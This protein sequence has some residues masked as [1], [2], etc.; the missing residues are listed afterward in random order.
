MS[1]KPVK[2]MSI[3]HARTTPKP[4]VANQ[5]DPCKWC[6]ITREDSNPLQDRRSEEDLAAGLLYSECAEF[7]HVDGNE[8]IVCPRIL[9]QRPNKPAYLREIQS[10]ARVKRGHKRDKRAYIKFRNAGG[11]KGKGRASRWQE[12]RSPDTSDDEEEMR[13]QVEA[14]QLNPETAV[15]EKGIKI[16]GRKCLGV[17]WPKELYT[18]K[19][20]VEPT[21]EELTS[22][23]DESGA[24]VAG[25]CRDPKHGVPFGSTELYAE[26]FDMGMYNTQLGSSANSRGGD[27]SEVKSLHDKTL[28][29]LAVGVETVTPPA[30]QPGQPHLKLKVAHA[31]KAK[32]GQES[33]QDRVDLCD[34][35]F[36]GG[37]KVAVQKKQ[38]AKS[39]SGKDV[40]SA[41]Q[42]SPAR[43]ATMRP[44]VDKR[45]AELAGAKKTLSDSTMVLTFLGDPNGYATVV[46]SSITDQVK[47]IEKHLGPQKRF[48]LPSQVGRSVRFLEW[49]A[50]GIT[51][52]IA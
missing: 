50:I 20:G 42:E 7:R 15:H 26:M 34:M 30:N 52:V 9:V 41:Q 23:L 46:E 40:V 39:P 43:A 2:K 3:K 6:D 51:V 10:D 48:L 35:G 18:D 38:Q 17:H 22:I 24:L 16:A 27:N 19:V 13:Q 5:L 36:L 37:I 31:P 47:K 49:P 33:M 11:G 14:S 25:V 8:C 29:R 12:C 4:K 21:E 32:R 28:K 44:A 45:F 1:A